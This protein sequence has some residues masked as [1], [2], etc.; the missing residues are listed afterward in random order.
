[1]IAR[2]LRPAQLQP[3][4]RRLAGQRRTI[5][6][7]RR[8]LAGQHRHP[9]VV[10]QLVV[11]DQIFIAQRQRKN[12]LPD[13]CPDSVLDQFRR[14]AVGKTLGKPIN[15]PDHPVRRSQQQGSGIRGHPAAIKSRHHPAAL[16]GC[17]SKQI[18]ATLC[19]HRVSPWP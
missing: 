14:A 15:Q 6:A 7:P 13:Q 10:A 19:R 1:M 3:I 2:Q 9:R 8:Q 12:P 16:D 4:E 11:I 18:R 17:K 5:L